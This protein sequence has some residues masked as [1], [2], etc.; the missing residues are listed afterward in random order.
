MT[1]RLLGLILA[2]ALWPSANALGDDS[3]SV[4]DE[5]VRAAV[6]REMLD[7][8]RLLDDAAFTIPLDYWKEF[9]RDQA[10]AHGV[11]QPPPVP[12]IA[13]AGE[14]HLSAP[15]GQSP[16]LQV[17]VRLHVFRPYLCANSPVLWAKAPGGWDAVAVNGKP[18]TLP[19]ADGWLRFSPTASGDFVITATSG[20]KD[21]RSVNLSIPRT[22]RTVLEFESPKAMEVA[23]PG[24]PR[25]IRGLA[26][27]QT[28]GSLALSPRDK[29]EFTVNPRGPETEHAPTFDVRGDVAWNF[30]AAG[31]TVTAA[32]DLAIVGGKTETI[33]LTLP[34]G[35]ARVTVTGPDVREA[36][37]DQ[38]EAGAVRVFLRGPVAERT[39]LELSFQLPAAGS[40]LQTV[41][42][43]AVRRGHWAGGSLVVTSTGGGSEAVQD[44]ATGLAEIALAD[45]PA[46]AAARLAGP[47]ALA[48]LITGRDWSAGVELLNLGEFALRESIA[49]AAH[50]EVVLRDDGSMMCQARFE[51]RNRNKQFLRVELPPGATAVL[52]RVNEQSRPLAPVAGQRDAYLLPLVRSKASLKGLV[53]FPVEL[54]AFYRVRPLSAAGDATLPLPRIDLPIA[55]A[56]CEAYLPTEMSSLKW[57]GVLQQVAR[58]ADETGGES[59]GY[60]HAEAAEKPAPLLLN[61]TKAPSPPIQVS[62]GGSIFGGVPATSNVTFKGAMTSGKEKELGLPQALASNYYRAGN[63]AYDRGDFENARQSFEQ[64]KKLAPASLEAANAERLLSNTSVIGQTSPTNNLGANF[65]PSPDE[66]AATPSPVAASKEHSRPAPKPMSKSE[67]VAAQEVKGELSVANRKLLENQREFLERGQNLSEQGNKAEALDQFRA[68]AALGDE[69]SARGADVLE[70]E[71]RSRVVKEQLAKTQDDLAQA[72]KSHE[73]GYQ[74]VTKDKKGLMNESDQRL[75]ENSRTTRKAVSGETS[76]FATKLSDQ[77]VPSDDAGLKNIEVIAAGGGHSYSGSMPATDTGRGGSGGGA[78]F[79]SG[80]SKAQPAT[81]PAPAEPPAQ[82]VQLGSNI[83][84]QRAAQTTHGLSYNGGTVTNAWGFANKPPSGLPENGALTP[85]DGRDYQIASVGGNATLY[86]DGTESPAEANGKMPLPNQDADFKKFVSDNYKWM[87][88]DQERLQ[89]TKNEMELSGPTPAL[90]DLADKLSRNLGQKVAVSSINLNVDPDS[91]AALGITFQSGANGVHY[92]LIDEA[93]FRTLAQLAPAADGQRSQETIVGT[94]ALFSNNFRGNVAYAADRYNNL[95]VKGNNFELP[96]EKYLLFNNGDN[97]TAVRTGAMQ[98]WK[99]QAAPLQFAAAPQEISVPRVGQ[100]VKFEKT[101]VKPTDDLGLRT[102]YEWKGATQ[103]IE[104]GTSLQWRLPCRWSWEL[105]PWRNRQVNRRSRSRRPRTLKARSS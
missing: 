11:A 49:D 48:Y 53:S 68:A 28:H 84:I 51:I 100:L 104:H 78:A 16:V 20:L 34:P 82:Q 47:A 81:P 59:F 54:V 103:C 40:G 102:H 6:V 41:G 69:L 90:G 93:Q 79:F 36:R 31:Q 71:H 99:D 85:T 2:C 30:D 87:G 62:G 105:L 56:K 77:P 38:G 74:T 14:Y 67:K 75:A 57:S 32:L 1:R 7:Q 63:E 12:L 88:K 60:G 98:F 101:L 46:S 55:Y 3:V 33:D 17:T 13:E 21:S 50:Y 80:S 70:Q 89:I 15:A 42:N 64:V 4:P 91:A 97:L 96:H 5:T 52:A 86:G 18:A 61:L 95:V 27:A 45:I 65:S 22:V 10:E 72:D 29:L 92:A 23:L 24:D 39:S 26:G 9:L 25:H 58:Y 8:S 19:E 43:L 37:P 66:A 76:R 73:L 44:S 94:D 35:A 83:A